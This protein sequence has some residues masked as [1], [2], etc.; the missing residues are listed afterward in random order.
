MGHIMTF[1][2]PATRN[3]LTTS[4]FLRMQE[5]DENFQG[6]PYAWVLTMTGAGDRSFSW[7][8]S[9]GIMWGQFMNRPHYCE[10]LAV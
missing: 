4:D 7:W 5:I 10:G 9:G 1:N 3:A 6:D 2:N 8:S